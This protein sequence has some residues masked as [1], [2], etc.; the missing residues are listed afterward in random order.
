MN[1]WQNLP[2]RGQQALESTPVVY[3]NG[4]ADKL[5]RQYNPT[6]THERTSY[7]IMHCD[8]CA[9]FTETVLAGRDAQTT[10]PTSE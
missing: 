1:W 10:E 3:Q 5:F 7:D 8:A 6:C 2:W 4:T 9:K